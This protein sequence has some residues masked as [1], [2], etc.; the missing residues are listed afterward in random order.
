MTSS[1]GITWTTQISAAGNAW[2]SVCW[3]PQ[4]GLF[5]AV[6]DTGTGDRVMTSS[7]GIT[8]TT[9]ISAA[10]NN[11]R[12]ICWSPELGLFVAV[13]D[14]GAGNRVMTSP[15]GITWTSRTSAA[16][17]IW[18]SICWSPELGLFVAVSADG[19]GTR[20]MTSS[21]QGRPPTSY[22]VF[23]DSSYNQ[24]DEFGDWTFNRLKFFNNE[25][26][27]IG[28]QAGQTNQGTNAIAIG[29]LAGVTNQIGGSICLNASGVALNP[30][31]TG[32]FVDPVR[33]D[34]NATPF[35]VYNTTTKEITYH[36]S[37][38][39]YKKNVVNLNQDTAKIYNT[40]PREYDSKS[41]NKHHIGYI[42]EE[43]N[44]IDANFTWKN[45]DG[46]PE[47]IEW[48]NLLIYA[49][50]EIKKL[51]ERIEILEKR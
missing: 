30:G 23:N 19:S 33:S 6:S 10:D 40:I 29:N 34:A 41:D 50:E 3:S 14:S 9:Q 42:A 48:F 21:L 12:S 1:N 27:R 18:Q 2:K 7:N 25:G 32:F 36:A 38:I 49:I 31:V 22:N 46:T 51:K 11:W 16:D 17:K 47:G 15:N 4:L 26:V 20:V 35:C 28:T 43:L 37:S 45:L 5:V 8:W 24:I 44:D 13:S 39:K